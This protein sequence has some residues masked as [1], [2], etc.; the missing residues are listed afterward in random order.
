MS[1][2]PTHCASGV[3]TSRAVLA[4]VPPSFEVFGRVP[5]CPT[6]TQ[7]RGPTGRRACTTTTVSSSPVSRSSRSAR[8]RI[9]GPSGPRSPATISAARPDSRNWV[10]VRSVPQRS[11]WTSSSRPPGR[12]RAEA[13]RQMRSRNA[14]PSRPAAQAR[15]PPRAGSR[16]A[17]GTYGGLDTIRSKR[18]SPTGPNRSPRSDLI[19]TPF[20]SPLRRALTVARRD[21]STAVTRASPRAADTATSPLPV[22]RSSTRSPGRTACL[23]HVA[24][25]RLSLSGRKTPGRNTSRT[26]RFSPVSRGANRWLTVRVRGRRR[27]WSTSPTP[28]GD[29]RAGARRARPRARV[30]ERQRRPQSGGSAGR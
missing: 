25:R 4:M 30:G 10:S 24:S 3:I 7:R 18:S 5:G 19:L 29:E 9:S 26:C 1:F 21:T 14:R 11:E 28:W 27:V 17:S 8:A 23:A 13:E 15:S 22:Q 16:S 20:R 12:S 6:R 2:S